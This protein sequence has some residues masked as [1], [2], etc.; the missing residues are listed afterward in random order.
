MLKVFDRY[1][2]SERLV[3]LLRFPQLAAG[4]WAYLQLI[5]REQIFNIIIHGKTNNVKINL[6]QLFLDMS[7]V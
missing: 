6:G 3:P 1:G 7:T 4:Q 5:L 2:G